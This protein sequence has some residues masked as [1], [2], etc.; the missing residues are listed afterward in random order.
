ME[1]D[2]LR[3]AAIETQTFCAKIREIFEKKIA[4]P[5]AVDSLT[6]AHKLATQVITIEKQLVD[7]VEFVESKSYTY[8]QTA[9]KLT[10]LERALSH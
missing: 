3:L 2:I 5:N 9:H 8:T 4:Q 10:A 6:L 1:N 7:L